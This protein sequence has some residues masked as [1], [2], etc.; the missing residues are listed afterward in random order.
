MTSCAYDLAI[1]GGGLGGSALGLAMAK[2]GARVLLIERE[3]AFRDRVRGEG[4][5]PWG[6][7][8]AR[9]LGIYDLL[10]D[11]CGNEVRFFD[12]YAGPACMRRDLPETTPQGLPALTFLHPEMQENLLTAAR[13]AGVEVRRGASVTGITPGAPPHITVS[14]DGKTEE[15]SARLVVGVDGRTS[16]A[17]TWGGF[18]V[19]Q[20]P[21]RLFIGGVLLEGTKAPA[22]A[23]SLVQGFG[24]GAIFFPQRDGRMR[25][26]ILYHRDVHE[27]RISGPTALPAFC[28]QA[29]LAGTPAD[30]V[31]EAR[32]VGPLATFEG[33]DSW[34]PHPYRDG[35]VLIGD[36][37]AAS[38]PSWGQGLSLTLRDVRTL[39]D[40]LLAHEDW[41]AAGHAYA[42]AHDRYYATLRTVEDWNTK[43]FMEVGEAADA[44]RARA[45][46]L[47][48]ADPTRVPDVLMSGPMQPLGEAERIRF[49]G[50]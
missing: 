34:V 30:W 21:H 17:R 14:Q 50:E 46:P 26:Y 44:R 45:L 31:S 36:A 48:M 10:R 47:I 6:C 18:T 3:E 4:M 13:E 8:E 43:L 25:A 1:I 35:V 24:R 40:Q 5:T 19:N 39:R 22:D 15:I 27:E 33:A 2:R 38:D 28:E 12:T 49:I 20:D 41:D 32:A 7:A 37:A 11:A 9:E 29:I 16:H 42:E 23:V